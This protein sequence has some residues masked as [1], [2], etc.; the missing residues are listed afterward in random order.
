M[1]DEARQKD[2]VKR[3]VARHLVGDVNIAALGVPCLRQHP[4]SLAQP[5][6]RDLTNVSLE[7]A[8]KLTYPDAE[9]SRR[10]SSE[11]L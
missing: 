5:E 9:R 7:D 2:E 8:P 10:N 3:P 4:E 6:A 11:R 1:C